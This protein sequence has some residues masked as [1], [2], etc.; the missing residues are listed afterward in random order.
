M[1]RFEI[2]SKRI[3]NNESI[4]QTLSEA[5][6]RHHCRNAKLMFNEAVERELIGSN[7][8]RKLTSASVEAV[9]SVVEG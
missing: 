9:P 4:E 5:S 8:F 2:V 1:T 7:P 6:V 3:V